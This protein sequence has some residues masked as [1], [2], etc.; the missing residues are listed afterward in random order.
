[1][2]ACWGAEEA[3]KGERPPLRCGASPGC[4]TVKSGVGDGAA[5]RAAGTAAD[6]ANAAGPDLSK[7][8]SMSTGGLAGSKGSFLTVALS[9]D[10][11]RAGGGS[12]GVSTGVGWVVYGAGVPEGAD[13]PAVDI[14]EEDGEGPPPGAG[15]SAEGVCCCLKMGS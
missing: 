11:S 12:L 7:A 2:C 8:G 3:E 9:S 6:A 4:S 15:W 1:M 13:C 14:V 10:D 5:V